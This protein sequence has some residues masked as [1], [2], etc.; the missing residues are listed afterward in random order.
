MDATTDERSNKLRSVR[1]VPMRIRTTDLTASKDSLP[2]LRT[3]ELADSTPVPHFG[4]ICESIDCVRVR[5]R[6]LRQLHHALGAVES[7]QYRLRAQQGCRDL[8]DRSRRRQMRSDFDRRDANKD[9]SAARRKR[10]EQ[11]THELQTHK[12]GR[13][14]YPLALRMVRFSSSPSIVEQH[15]VRFVDCTIAEMV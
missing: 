8:C 3:S 1:P 12:E 11:G 5:V 4:P 9:D 2:A 7:D 6:E 13:T 14:S 10:D 15:V